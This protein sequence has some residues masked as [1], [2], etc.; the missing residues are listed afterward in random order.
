[1]YC[2]SRRVAIGASAVAIALGCALAA[3]VSTSFVTPFSSAA[4]GSSLPHG[5]TH[6]DIK[7]VDTRTRYT[8]ENDAGTTVLRAEAQS[9]ASAV[10]HRMSIP[11]ASDVQ[12][13]WRWKISDVLKTS[14]PATKEGDDYAARVYVM[15]DYPLEKL[16]LADRIKLKLARAFYDPNVPA[17]ALC[18]VWDSRTRTE[19][20]LTSPYTSRVRIIVASSGP[21]SAGQW[22]T[23]ERNVG[24]DFRRAFGEEPPAISAVAVATDTDNTRERVTAW[25]GDIVVKKRGVTASAD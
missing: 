17:A 25:Y 12:L 15:F 19:T 4:P 14:N 2:R 16:P 23:V 21:P 3:P 7:G 11:G 5:W 8:L 13:Q 10:V 22:Q 6:A 9:S 18:Y 24:E 20:L 1:M